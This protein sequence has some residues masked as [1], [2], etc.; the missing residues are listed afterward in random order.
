MRGRRRSPDTKSENGEHSCE[1]PTEVGEPDS[2]FYS[3]PSYLGIGG[4]TEIADR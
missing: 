3:S 1:I 2:S 4:G